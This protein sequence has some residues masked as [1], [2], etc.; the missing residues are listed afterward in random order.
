VDTAATAGLNERVYA[1]LLRAYP[2]AFRRRYRDEMVLLFTDQLRDARPAG[3]TGIAGTWFRTI[4]DLA[5]SAIGEHLRK[6]RDVAM[7]LSSFEPTRS[8]R[9][10]GLL[11]M[12]GG[13][14]LVAVFFS[15]GLFDG[16]GNT[17][18]LVLFALA[19][20]A[21]AVAF[22][23]RQSA[24][25]PRLAIVGTVVVVIAGLAYLAMNVLALSSPDSAARVGGVPYSLSSLSL[26]LGAGVY[27]AL[28]LRTGSASRG[29]ARWVAAVARMAA[30]IL[31]VGGPVAALGD[32]RWGLTRNE[33]FGELI[34]QAAL[35][36]VFLTGSGWALLGAVLVFGGRRSATVS[37]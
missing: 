12:V 3:G 29:M 19:G 35:V 37:R 34:S 32:D 5:S 18:R 20:I 11:A 16:P 24:V 26:W 36:G 15:I 14:V 23:S 17:I 2:A 4:L 31:L 25:A 1:G 28:A 10:L 9:F 27:G 13:S 6:D 22:H 33:A 30:W 21:V 7:S 8:M